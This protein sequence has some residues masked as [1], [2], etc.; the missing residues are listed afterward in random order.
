MVVHY[1]MQAIFV[2]VGLLALGLALFNP[3]WFFTA[4]NSQF[5]VKNAGRKKTRFFYAILGCIMIAAGIFF[6]LKVYQSS[7]L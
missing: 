3:E 1:I 5:I 6:F 4:H 2:L 7:N